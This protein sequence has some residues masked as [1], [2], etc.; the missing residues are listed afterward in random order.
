MFVCRESGL[1]VDAFTAPRVTVSL[2]FSSKT[3]DEDGFKS[4]IKVS[5]FV[6]ALFIPF[7]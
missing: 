3:I 2:L 7:I 1:P 4:L 6:F 5:K